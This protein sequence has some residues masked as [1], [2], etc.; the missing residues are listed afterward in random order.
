[1]RKILR[2]KTNV[3]YAESLNRLLQSGDLNSILKKP[4]LLIISTA[5]DYERW[6]NRITKHCL[7]A[8]SFQWF[9]CTNDYIIENVTTMNRIFDFIEEVSLPKKTGILGIG[10]AAIADLCGNV[11][12]MNQ[13]TEELY[14]IATE[15]SGFIRVLQGNFR[16]INDRLVSIVQTKYDAELLIYAAETEHK[17]QAVLSF[18]YLIQH[19]IV[20]NRQL[21]K[22]IYQVS[23]YDRTRFT[24]Y[25]DRLLIDYE[26]TPIKSLVFGNVFTTG[27]CKAEGSHYLNFMQKKWLGLLLQFFWCNEQLG[28]K[29]KD[30]ELIRWFQWLSQESLVIPENVLSTDL[31]QSICKESRRY[32]DI[33]QLLVETT[34]GKQI[35]HPTED[36]LLRVVEKLRYQI[37]IEG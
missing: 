36:G 9:I 17:D 12:V 33:S 15:F 31:C 28:V 35:R 23:Y 21:L 27:I 20:N 26:K 29:M 7:S 19:A 16:L 37:K 13:F 22:T 4:S 14:F 8:D 34:E 11:T 2:D 32:T 1:M 5:E 10:N 6:Y 30:K 18:F 3:I 24:S 25:C